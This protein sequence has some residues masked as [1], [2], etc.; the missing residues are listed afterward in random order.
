M[1]VKNNYI[2]MSMGEVRCGHCDFTQHI[3]FDSEIGM[4]VIV[5]EHHSWNCC[6]LKKKGKGHV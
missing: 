4:L 3:K 2:L 1:K 6:T 5:Q